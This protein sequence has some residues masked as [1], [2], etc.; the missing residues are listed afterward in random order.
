M[1][2]VGQYIYSHD[3]QRTSASL[4]QCLDG[5]LANCLGVGKPGQTYV[6]MAD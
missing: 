4:E 5:V 1:D 2:W 3:L 6:P